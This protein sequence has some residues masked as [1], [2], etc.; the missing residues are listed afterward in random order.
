MSTAKINTVVKN[1]FQF[2]KNPP[3]NTE[4]LTAKEIFTLLKKQY[5]VDKKGKPKNVISAYADEIYIALF[6]DFRI[7]HYKLLILNFPYINIEWMKAV[8]KYRFNVDVVEKNNSFEI[9]L[10]N[11]FK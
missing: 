4:K 9:D 11:F 10:T 3:R 1:S 8:T 5:R 2:N 6:E 7:G